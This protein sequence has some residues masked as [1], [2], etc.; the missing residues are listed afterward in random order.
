M[1]SQLEITSFHQNL[2][3]SHYRAIMSVEKSDDREFYETES[4]ECGWNKRELERQKLIFLPK[5]SLK[6]S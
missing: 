6:K 5:K 3:W 1:G 4:I 2:S